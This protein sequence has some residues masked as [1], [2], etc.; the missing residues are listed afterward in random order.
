MHRARYTDLLG[1]KIGQVPVI[2]M[3]SYF[4]V[5]YIAWTIASVLIGKRD[6]GISGAELW[7]L[8]IL[9]SFVMVMWDLGL[10][11]PSATI[12]GEW[13]WQQG[14]PY[15]GVPLTNFGGWFLCVF[16]FY[17]I[18]ALFLRITRGGAEGTAI[19]TRAYWVLPILAYASIT[20][21]YWSDLLQGER[22]EITDKAGHVWHTGD[23]YDSAVLISTFTMLFVCL[24]GLVLIARTGTTET[25]R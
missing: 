25:T 16:T 24:L 6:D 23:I 21:E 9:S 11:P 15:F 17:L 14:G 1:S 19:T 13:V 12:E 18:F 3:P 2:I 5:G 8:P 4:A 10:D 22:T 7:L 20:V